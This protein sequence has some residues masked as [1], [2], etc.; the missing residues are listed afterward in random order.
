MAVFA[1]SRRTLRNLLLE[2]LVHFTGVAMDK[3]HFILSSD[4]RQVNQNQ[5]IAQ[6]AQHVPKSYPVLW[7]RLVEAV[8]VE[9]FGDLDAD[10]L[11]DVV[12][13][14]QEHVASAKAYIYQAYIVC[15]SHLVNKLKGFGKA[16]SETKRTVG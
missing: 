10:D 8:C 9:L 3:V 13:D 4:K 7:G 6:A 1:P 16:S 12:Q 5:S 14:W 2:P 11:A 15:A